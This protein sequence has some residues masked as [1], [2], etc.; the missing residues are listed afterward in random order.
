MENKGYRTRQREAI[1]EFLKRSGSHH[2]SI[3]EVLEHLKAEGEKVGRTTIYR[4]MEKLTEE[5]T[6]RKYFI[7]EGVGA[8]YQYVDSAQGCHEHF[9]LKCLKCG[10][11][12]HVECDYLN[13]VGEHIGEHHGFVVDNTKTVLYGV[14]KDC[15]ILLG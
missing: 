8:C 11:L 7:E 14:C 2:V 3:E 12:L 5:G 9:H 13:K 4:Y 15:K 6:L 10:K 1:L